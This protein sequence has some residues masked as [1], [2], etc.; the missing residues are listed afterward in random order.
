MSST[1]TVQRPPQRQRDD[2]HDGA[3]IDRGPNPEERDTDTRH[4]RSPDSHDDEASA[5]SDE[6]ERAFRGRDGHVDDVVGRKK[7]G[8]C[9]CEEDK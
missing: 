5:E 9:E 1:P 2:E 6:R 4:P 3:R 7:G 8:R